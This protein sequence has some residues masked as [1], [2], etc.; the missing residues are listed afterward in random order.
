MSINPT[1]TILDDDRSLELRETRE[2]AAAQ[3]ALE[4]TPVAEFMG[5]EPGDHVDWDVDEH[6]GEPMLV[7][8]E[9]PD[10]QT[11]DAPYPRRLREENGETVAPV[12][13]P[14]VRAEPPAGLGLDLDAYDA[15]RP[16]LFDALTAAETIGVVPVRFGDGEPYRSEPLPNV[17][18][19][20]DPI[21]EGTIEHERDGDSTPR[22]ETMDAPIDPVVFD[23]VMADAPTDVPEADVVGLLEASETHD[24][25]GVDDH[26]AG[27]PPL[28]V[29]DRAVVRLEDGAWQSRIAPDLEN[30]GVDVDGNAL[31]VVRTIHERQAER[32]LEETEGVE[33]EHDGF[34]S[35][36]ALFVTAERDTAE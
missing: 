3:L 13:D 9:L 26:A 11:G 18:D 24:V 14:L 21:A 6:E 29:D 17:A 25:V 28:S 4:L 30:A 1:G 33:A 5:A 20:S 7:L 35:V 32:L 36:S 31:G 34:E 2:S 10:E 22:P 23:D 15:E 12:P 19:A 27:T 8:S 16:L